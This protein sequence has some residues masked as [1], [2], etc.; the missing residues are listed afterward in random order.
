MLVSTASTQARYV[1]DW[2]PVRH[3]ASFRGKPV[4]F[5]INPPA[6]LPRAALAKGLSAA[7]QRLRA[8]ETA[9]SRTPGEPLHAAIT[10]AVMAGC[11]AVRDATGGYFDPWAMPGGFTPDGLLTGWAMEQAAVELR[12]AGLCDVAVSSGDELLVRGVAPGGKPWRVGIRAP[13]SGALAASVL[14]QRLVD[15]V[16]C[17]G[18]GSQGGG[19]ANTGV[20]LATTT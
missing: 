3:S 4:E 9:F 7:V 15:E 14:P 12:E 13:G 17:P 6:G 1:I 11:R 16:R 18:G 8:V 20:V 5:R 10:T 2:A 19:G